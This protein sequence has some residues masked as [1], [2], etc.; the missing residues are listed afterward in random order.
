MLNISGRRY[1][2]EGELHVAGYCL[3]PT[4]LHISYFKNSTQSTFKHEIGLKI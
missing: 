1:P 3:K 4:S 2:K